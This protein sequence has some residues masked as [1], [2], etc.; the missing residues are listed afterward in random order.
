[1]D[2]LAIY[3]IDTARPLVVLLQH[4]LIETGDFI[5]AAPIY[6]DGSAKPLDVITPRILHN[7]QPYL[8]GTHLMSAIPVRSLSQHVGSAMAH[9]YDISRALSRLFFGN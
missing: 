7:A 3:Q 5:F 2:H 4:P 9:E 8:L 1:M 6:P